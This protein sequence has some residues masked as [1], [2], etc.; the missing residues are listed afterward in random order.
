MQQ[1]PKVITLAAFTVLLSVGTA[2]A[3]LTHRAPK[4]VSDL[5]FDKSRVTS[6]RENPLAVQTQTENEWRSP[7]A[8][9]DRLAAAANTYSLTM[10]LPDRPGKQFTQLSF[11][12]RDSSNGATTLLLDLASTRAFTGTSE[13][14][15]SAIA[16][17]RTWIDET[18]TIWVD[19][20]QP[21]SSKTTLTIVFKAKKQPSK[22]SYQYGIAAYPNTSR[23]V[24]IFV[25]NET[26]RSN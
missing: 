21:V 2:V 13:T 18:G 1:I 7:V 14:A 5:K 12:E 10:T 26:L 23:P 22:A 11:T 8:N 25:G 16:L 19:F 9:Q 15:G 24:A 3:N 17:E 20:K 4:S 6:D